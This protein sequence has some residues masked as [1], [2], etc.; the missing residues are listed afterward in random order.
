MPC[1]VCGGRA[2][3]TDKGPK[4]MNAACEGSKDNPEEQ[5]IKCTCG[6][7]MEYTGINQLGEPLYSCT[8]CRKS[9]KL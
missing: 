5:Q 6:E 9:I 8:S 3:K 7:V 2:V 4:C 1:A